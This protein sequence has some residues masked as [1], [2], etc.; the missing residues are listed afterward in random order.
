MA[1]SD[2]ALPSGIAARPLFESD[3]NSALALSLEAGWNQVAAD[4]RIFL[5]LGSVTCL[6]RGDGPPIATAATLPYDG[7]FAWISTVLVTAAERRQGLARWLMRHCIEELLARKLVPV[8]DATPAGRTVYVGLGFNDCWPMHRLVG[9]TV[10]TPPA[11]SNAVAVRTLTADDWPQVIAY[12]TAVFGAERSALLRRLADRLPSAALVAERGG[13]IVGFLLGR[14]GRVMSQLGPLA[15]DDDAV[16]SALLAQAIA[17]TSAPLTIDV[18]DHH[19]GL[20]DWLATLG[21]TAERLLTRMVHGTHV[22]FDDGA[23]LFAIAG[24]E[25]G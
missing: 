19:A 7:S 13:R 3:L 9:R 18:P 17:V 12:D 21:F 16:A 10:R 23:R 2:H 5:E 24:P 8:L 4:W 22:A 15:A 20:H 14:D 6:T 11:I 25:L 1:T